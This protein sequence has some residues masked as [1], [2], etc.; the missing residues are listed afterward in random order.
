LH[1]YAFFLSL[2]VGA[3]L[4]G[5]AA[6]AREVVSASIYAGTVATMF[7]A[8]A[9]Y[10]RVTWSPEWRPRIRQLDH[11]MIY[12]LIAGSYTPFGLLVLSGAW[13]VSV[14]TIVWSGVGAAITLSFVWIDAPKW[15]TACIG[16]ALGWVA[17]VAMPLLVRGIGVVGA[18][19]VL[20][21]G[22]F[23]TAGAIVYACRRPDPLPAV[24]GYHELFHA[25]VIAAVACQYVSVAFFVL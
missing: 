13:Q 9:L 12:L 8:S 25:C 23:Y 17:I 5:G 16:I 19:L 1:Q 18:L 3:L 15:L 10:N 21:G 6:G 14:L 4:V 11:S 7:G 2:V 20:G 24:F 22:L